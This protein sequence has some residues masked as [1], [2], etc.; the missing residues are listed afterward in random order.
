MVAIL[1]GGVVVLYTIAYL[2]CKLRDVCGEKCGPV[3]YQ[4][5][6]HYNQNANVVPVHTSFLHPS[7]HI[8][9]LSIPQLML[10][11]LSVCVY[12]LC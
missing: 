6:P 7:P 3:N 12:V 2:L 5:G 1:I 10:M 4:R 9:H 11:S 8:S